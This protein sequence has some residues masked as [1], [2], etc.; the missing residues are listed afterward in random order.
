MCGWG[1]E[2]EGIEVGVDAYAS[3]LGRKNEINIEFCLYC[4]Q[5][6]LT[7]RINCWFSWWPESIKVN[8]LVA[9]VFSLRGN[10]GL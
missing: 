5:L 8:D 1:L 7:S 9:S 4:K 10:E 2:A 3:S 6:K